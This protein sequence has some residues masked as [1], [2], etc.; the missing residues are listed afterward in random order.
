MKWS[1]GG[2]LVADPVAS[3]RALAGGAVVGVGEAAAIEREAAAADALGQPR[4]EPLELGD[5]LVDPLR[6]GGGEARPVAALR[7]LVGR[8]LRQLR[9]D[10]L[11]AEA[12]PMKAI[13]RRTGRG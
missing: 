6:P 13:R 9:A 1:A 8:Q 11:E 12:D 3:A 10:L 5:A 4:L 7:R 2:A